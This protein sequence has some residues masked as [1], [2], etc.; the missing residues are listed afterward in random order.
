LARARHSHIVEILSHAV[1]DDGAFQL[2]CLPFLGG[3]TLTSVLDQRR[4]IRRPPSSR[5]GLLRDLDAVAAPEYS[6]ANPASPA[7]EI[8]SSLSDFRA[9]AWITARLADAL[10][11]AHCRDVIHGDVKPSNI[12][13]TADGNPMLLDFNLARNW[14]IAQPNA[15]LED[16]GGTLAYMAPERLQSLAKAGSAPF[17]TR[18]LNGDEPLERDDPHRA[19]IYSLGIVLLE[20]LTLATPTEIMHDRD[21]PAHT[22]GMVL[23]LAAEYGSFRQR[24][25][26]AVI[27]ASETAAG[28]RIPPALRAILE[29]CLA[30]RP[31]DRYR[32]SLELAED[33]DRWRTD[34]PL[35][36]AAEPFW[37]QTLPRS[38]R[39][40]KKLLLA[41][42]LALVM[43]LGMTYLVGSRIQSRLTLKDMAMY[44]L[45]RNWD[46]MESHAFQFQRPATPRL[47]SQ[48]A[49]ETM[50]T[51]THALKEYDVL[52]RGDWRQRE[53]VR[54]LPQTDRD[55]LAL[56][57][58]EQTLRYC[59]SLGDRPASPGDWCRAIAALDRV[60]TNPPLRAFETLRWRLYARLG[61]HGSSG[62]R[63]NEQIALPPEPDSGPQSR[64]SRPPEPPWLEDYLL[65]VA[66]ELEGEPDPDQALQHYESVLARSP[67]SFWGHY[68]AAVV[69]FQLQ[70]WSES[71]RHLDFC[72]KRR[73]KN[74]AL[75]GQY[76]SCL[77]QLGLLDDALQECNRA[78]DSAPDY[79]EFYRS[80]AFILARRRQAEGL[81]DDLRRFE[82]LSRV[83]TRGFF[84][85]PPGQGAGNP[86]PAT[87]PASQRAL[88]LDFNPGFTAQ[89][90]N[91]L[92]DSDEIEPDEL[93]A[94]AAL[95]VAIGKA[96]T[97]RFRDEAAETDR[98]TLIARASMPYALAIAD[99]EL[100]KILTL[101]PQ[102]IT[103][104]MARMMQSLEQGHLQEARNDLV[105]VLNYPNLIAELRKKPQVFPF[106][107]PAAERFARHGL[108]A[109]ALRIADMA[110]SCSKE[111]KQ[112][113][114]QSHYYKAKVLSVAA[115][116]DST[117]VALAAE[118][119]QRAILANH[120][121]KEWYEGDKV[122]DPVRIRINA[123]LDQ[124]P[125]IIRND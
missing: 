13:L 102:H 31:A 32:R 15:P 61:Q 12:L 81:E 106:L 94:R 53:E 87:V 30:V 69:C 23:D 84:R 59:R 101:D 111:L 66:A 118:Q 56:W 40:H 65:G 100:E 97:N 119:L 6:G 63:T 24:G 14:S 7:R 64:A 103:A 8:L 35:A 9:I 22:P 78:L 109:E 20:A 71:A 110:V 17:V 73:Y 46:D 105:L 25:T 104:R 79:A 10:D 18:R 1:V 52:G 39:R 44:K 33:L 99:A 36:Y 77:G 85:N 86:L 21:A 60:G 50:A 57:L 76:A 115:R 95:A 108:I 28:Q 42:G 112:Y 125:E 91:P 120:R 62:S 98:S 45:A 11:H 121:F 3:A 72:V 41:S 107:H 113:Q 54:N 2:I 96:G 19:D 80:R 38:A 114:G 90:G 88:D 122:F 48:N 27:R 5:G 47:H 82:L 34:L 75:H 58:M 49:P 16:P 83:L 116:S 29:R 74:A 89:P 51:A 123:A 70:G 68:R 93:D 55:D 43:C 124:L 92:V 26:M 67:D 117:Q 37:A 4:R